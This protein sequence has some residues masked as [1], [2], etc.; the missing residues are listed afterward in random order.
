MDVGALAGSLTLGNVG[1]Q[2][3]IGVLSSTQNLEQDL[4]SRLFGSLGI[5]NNVDVSA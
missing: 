5:G 4:V 1:S 3:A 2:V